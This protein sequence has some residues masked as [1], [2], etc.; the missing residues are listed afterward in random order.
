[1]KK[2]IIALFIS[3]LFLDC[4]SQKSDSLMIRGF[5]NEALT[6]YTAYHQLRYLCKEI[7]GRI[8]CTPQAA[9]AVE[10]AKQE[11]EHMG[12]DTVYL[13]ECSVRCWKRGEPE[14]AAVVSALLG[15]FE[16]PVCALGGSVGTGNAGLRARVVEVKSMEELKELGKSKIKGK[17]VFFNRPAEPTF[18]NTFPSYGSAADQRVHGAAMAASYGALG[19]VVRSLTLADDEHPH[20]GIMRYRDSIP[21]IPAI[22]IGTA[23]ADKLSFWLK[24]DPDLNFFFRTTCEERPEGI[25]YNV[26]GELKGSEKPDEIICFGGHLDAWDNGEG[27]H[28]D[29]V[30]VVQTIEA[31]RL[32]MAT[33]CQP[34]HTL[35]VVVFMDEE[36]AQRGGQKYAAE[37]KR[38]GEKILA[39]IESDRGGFTPLGFSVDAGEAVY[40]RMDEWRPYFSAYGM[41]E[42]VHGYSGVDIYPLKEQG[43]PLFA[44]MTDSQRYFDYQHAPN[45]VF[46]NV[47]RREMQLGSAAIATLIYLIDRYGF[48]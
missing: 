18:I 37:V 13:Q 33:E 35:R 44:L 36:V 26:I 12:L 31:L 24:Q 4:Q 7:G 9:A 8:C 45:D 48:N 32:F 46:E 47:N 38:K 14:Q 30:G 3:F 15:S 20:T 27:A 16:P 34:K 1:M 25:S 2:I 29:G 28:D 19:V 40:R 42:I 22:A 10:W 23:N 5:Y 6:D 21:A 43:I 41:H 39:A 17:I 11:L